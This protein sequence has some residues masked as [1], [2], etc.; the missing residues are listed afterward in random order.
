MTLKTKA[1]ALSSGDE[2]AA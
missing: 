1:V 2:R